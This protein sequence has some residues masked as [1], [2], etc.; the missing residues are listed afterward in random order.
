MNNKVLKILLVEDNPGDALLLDEMLKEVDNT[1]FQLS[2][3]TRLDEGL[4][5]LLKDS[6]DLLLLDLGLPDSQGIDTFTI[7]NQHAPELPIIILTGLEDEKFAINAV[8][9]GAQDYLVKG[10]VDSRLLVRSIKYAIERK[11]IEEA[12]RK[13]E[14]KYRNIVETAQSGILLTDSK[15]NISYV[16]SR[17]ANMLGYTV[18][19]LLGQDLFHLVDEE[20]QEKAETYLKRRGEGINEITEFKF[21]RKDGSDLWA[22]ISSNPL[23]NQKEQYIGALGVVTD[24]T[25]R[26]GV[27]KALIER[28]KH[29]NLITANMMDVVS[30]LAL[31]EICDV[32]SHE[33][34][35]S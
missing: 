24:I 26:K 31:K 30:H 35:F 33:S 8:G 25:A 3:T 34:K 22:L 9:T 13:S 23:F 5:Y 20:G 17:M 14:E 6:F 4:K 16:N 27:E 15:G 29:L 18:Q 2:H 19:K 10:Q 21:I 1:H 28:Q 7:M 32:S 11:R 12:L